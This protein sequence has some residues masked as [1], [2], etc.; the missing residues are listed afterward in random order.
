[1]KSVSLRSSESKNEETFAPDACALRISREGRDPDWDSFLVSC[2]GGHHEQTS[3]WA[4]VKGFYGWQPFRI[5][6]SREKRILGGVQVLTRCF[7]RWGRIGY[8][9]RGPLVASNDPGLIDFILGQLD[10]AAKSERLSYLAVVLPYTGHV[11][12]PGLVRL[13]FRQKPNFLPPSG[14]MTATLVLD[15]S[16]D[17]DSLMARMRSK[18]RQ[19]IRRA[20]RKG[21]MVREGS[22]ADVETFRRLMCA[23]CERRGTSPTPPQKDFFEHLWRTYHPPG[24]V[25]LFIAELEGLVI[26]ALITFPFGDTVQAWKIGWAGDHAEDS[27]N[28]MLY[29]EAIRWSK[30][31]GYR[32]FD[33]V[34]I[35]KDL[36]QR[37]QQGDPVDWNSVKG[38]SNFKV[39]FGGSPVVL[40][41]PYYR[42]YHP[43]LRFLARAGGSRMIESP[44][45]AGFLGRF[46]DRL[47]SPGEG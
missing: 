35:E 32:F 34:S 26:S 33:F 40:P 45:V 25:R 28:E 7:G 1:M 12:E 42:F 38:P 10:H 21:V 23:L 22:E 2:P 16:S 44:V 46:W 9:T 36:A 37:L 29:W 41:V 20:F 4:E 5:V 18:T 17:L 47:A 8:V 13:G 30:S 39:A 14:L 27:P 19:H 31:N 15:L 11:F 3:L 43:I 24:F 6:V